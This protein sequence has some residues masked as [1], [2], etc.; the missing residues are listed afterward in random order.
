MST[1]SSL[2]A[3]VTSPRGVPT[4]APAATPPEPTP[5]GLDRN[6]YFRRGVVKS[7]VTILGVRPDFSE[8]AEA[9]SF[10]SKGGVEA[11]Y[12]DCPMFARGWAMP[13]ERLVAGSTPALKYGRGAHDAPAKLFQHWRQQLETVDDLAQIEAHLPAAAE[14]LAQALAP[15]TAAFVH[16]EIE[17]FLAGRRV[18]ERGASG[19][20]FFA[21]VLGSVMDT[22]ASCYAVA[23]AFQN[24]RGVGGR[25]FVDPQVND[26]V[27]MLRK[28]SA[29]AD[30]AARIVA[31]LLT[32][33][34]AI[35]KRE[36]IER[37]R[38]AYQVDQE[39]LAAEEEQR[40]RAAEEAK[41]EKIAAEDRRRAEALAKLDE[42]R[43]QREEQRAKGGEERRGQER[44]VTASGYDSATAAASLKWGSS[45]ALAREAE[46]RQAASRARRAADPILG[47]RPWLGEKPRRPPQP[48]P[49]PAARRRV[50][51]DRGR[52]S[53]TT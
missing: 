25:D 42:E 35:E 9:S 34:P 52:P 17:A 47:A 14:R 26:V 32:L 19:E 18:K 22:N 20:A 4:I 43:R 11:T 21:D 31:G 39:R 29:N 48:S 46:D 28:W 30:Y 6:F 24:L 45:G 27:A 12:H 44:N 33:P 49:Q 16:D 10:G 53:D 50:R 36:T 38:A 7:A 2:P 15:A 40:K 13:Y 37:Q 51:L 5:F 3:I 1:K 41:R 8:R 23:A